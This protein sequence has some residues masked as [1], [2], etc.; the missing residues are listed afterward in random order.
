MKLISGSRYIFKKK[1][2]PQAEDYLSTALGAE[3]YIRKFEQETADGIYWK[4]KGATWSEVP[5]EE[6]DLSFYS[7]N[8]GILFFYLKLYETTK[9]EEYLERINKSA[10]YIAKHW[11]E[12]FNQT[13]IFGSDFMIKG[14]YMG[15][16]GIGL[17]LLETYKATGN[18]EA[19]IAALEVYE[20]YK[21]NVVKKDDGIAWSDSPAVAMDGGVILFFLEIYKVF[22]KEET[23]KLILQAANHYLSHGISH[24]TKYGEA[25]EFRGWPGPGTRPNYEFGT[26]GAGYVLTL[27]YELNGEEKYLEAAKKADHYMRSIKVDQ[28]KGYL[29]PYDE[30]QNPPIYFLSSCHG[31]GGNSKLYYKLYEI[32]KDPDYLKQI[33]EMV[34]GIESVGAPEKTSDGF[35]NTLCFCCG[36]AGMVHYFLGLYNTLKEDRY[37][38]LA[39]RTASILIGEAKENE[40]NSISWPMAFWRVKPDYLTTDLGFYDGIAGIGTALL[41]AYLQEKNEFKW[42]RLIDD[43][44]RA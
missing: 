8:T 18:E 36:H 13:P 40:D 29:H 24:Q 37:L 28:V 27:L 12:Y 25:L 2:N 21:E 1:Q 41:E 10:A 19:K 32:T 38:D 15:I 16:G 4:K 35:W 3:K 14:L 7:G 11:K 42:A 43:P 5:E 20:Y 6:I 33:S 22:E 39:K 23:R 34:D 44:F 26:A 31:V 9:K 17:I 30:E